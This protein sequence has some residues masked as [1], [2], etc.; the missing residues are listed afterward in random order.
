M[1]FGGILYRRTEA[2]YRMSIDLSR[3]PIRLVAAGAVL[4]ALFGT[5]ALAG[6]AW[7]A[8]TG[9]NPAAP[10]PT[11]VPTVAVAPVSDPAPGLARVARTTTGRDSLFGRSGKLRVRYL[12]QALRSLDL[13]WLSRLLG[14]SV[15]SR[16]GVY[17]IPDSAAGRPLSLIALLP[18]DRKTNGRIGS[19]RIGF[20]PAELGRR[21]VSAAYRNPQGFIEVTQQNQHTQVSEHFRLR[22]FLTK[23]QHNVWPKYLVLR[24]E[25]VDKLELVIDE[26][27][28]SGI[29]VRRVTVMSGFRTP[30]YNGPGGDGRSS[31][32]RHMYG[33]AADIFV[34]ND[35]DGRMD[36]LD[37]N[38]RIDAR[39]A[40]VIERAAERVERRHPDLMGGVG[41]YRATRSHGPFA[42]IDV[43]GTRARW[44]R[45]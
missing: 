32:S 15:A 14:D 13:P 20:W 33:D 34:D 31:V 42:H 36:D 12:T 7:A 21:T 26:L 1:L 2:A 24:T 25:L 11:V 23:D 3:P 35:G 5:A 41:I 27:Q 8:R 17:A 19:Y 16:P 39:D 6:E 18:F 30:Q 28:A 43:R 4:G 38:G 9:T 22:D 29:P 45:S 44:G 37:R 10:L 40:A